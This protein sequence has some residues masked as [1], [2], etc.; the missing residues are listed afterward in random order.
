MRFPNKSIP[1]LTMVVLLLS[2]T[3]FEPVKV[4]KVSTGAVTDITQSSATVEGTVLEIGDAGITQHGFYFSTDSDPS[5][6]SFQKTELGSSSTTGS[7]S[8]LLTGLEP[9]T[10][11]NFMA[12]LKNADGEK[13]GD[14]KNFT[15]LA[16]SIPTV[17]T[18][19]VSSISQT[20]G[21][22]GGTVTDDGGSAVTARGICW[23]ISENPTISDSKTEDGD[24]PGNFVSSLTGLNCGT[25]YFVRAYSTNASGTAYGNQVS[26]TTNQCSANT[27]AL[28]TSPISSITETTAQSGGNVTNDGGSP[29]TIKG[30]CWST[31]ENPTISNSKSVDGNGTGG[32][33]S[34]ISG[35]SCG[36]TYYVR[37]Y[38]TNSSGTAYGNQISFTTSQ[39][40]ANPPTV[41]TSAISSITETTAQGGGEVTSDGGAAVTSKGVCWSTTE[42]PTISD[43]RTEDGTGTGSFT[44]A[45]ADLSCGTTYFV[46]AYATNSSGTSYGVQVSFETTTCPVGL[47][48]VSTS[49][50]TSITEISAQGG[51]SVTD[52]G[53]ASVTAKG[54]C[55]SVSKNPT[56]AD[57]KTND[58]AGTG[59]YTS[60]I[61]GLNCGTTY[62][63]RAYA[64]NTSGTEY[65]AEQAFSTTECPPELAT[66]TT[67]QISNITQTS[68]QGGGN[69][70]SDGG[71]NVTAKGVCWSTSKSPTVSDSKTTDGIGT[72]SFNSVI[73]GLSCGVIYYVRAYV[74]NSAGTA[75]GNEVS[76]TTGACASLP[77]VTTGG[78]S[79]IKPNSAELSGDVASDGGST[80]TAR[81]I[82]WSTSPNPSIADNISSDGSGVGTYT[83]NMTGLS[84][85]TTY[86]A[87]TYASNSAG[88]SYGVQVSFTTG[89]CATLPTVTTDAV[90]SI[91]EYTA[92][93]GGNVTSDGGGTITA[94]GVCWSTSVNPTVWDDFTKD[95]SGTGT[96]GSYMTGLNSYTTYYVRAYATNSTGTGYGNEVT[97][98]TSTVT[99]YDGNEY[100]IVT[101][102]NQ[103]WMA[104]NLNTT[105]YADGS[106]IP[107]VTSDS[108]WTGIGSDERAYCYFNNDKSNGDEY[109][110]L[111][112]WGAASNGVSGGSDTNPS[113]LQG[114][115]PAGYHLPSDAEYMELEMYLGMTQSDAEST[116]EIRGSAQNVGGKLKETGT[117]RWQA[118]NEYATNE[119]GFTAAAGGYRLLDARFWYLPR[120]A[121]YWTSTSEH[122]ATAYSRY[123]HGN[124]GYVSRYP[125][126]DKR[127]GFS[128]R[129]VK[130]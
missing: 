100:R 40:T 36:S 27:P 103:I 97:F 8:G 88:T 49:T 60:A 45:V 90:F 76:F 87:N 24:G 69:V 61:T 124:A 94:R 42:N 32:Y 16:A 35:L 9:G 114:V 13:Y 93:S 28:T 64:T 44:S 122:P 23:S 4:N 53:G 20:S 67:T 91:E 29:V 3:K 127:L 15:T 123:V 68:A 7:F 54:V 51:G 115:C 120:T 30:V 101:I 62:Y 39:C 104:D 73:S 78:L 92:E 106:S 43:N 109:G 108:E 6:G 129:C 46:R 128:V 1:V 56:I 58:G 98:K 26:F 22:G 79:N 47:P 12:Y 77:S 83:G 113:G 112:S 65:G 84:C 59:S 5:S 48:V 80:V 125:F 99:D 130:D 105:H 102:G 81:G 118:P 85:S 19:E 55:W 89:S 75:Y 41:T 18:T 14:I 33:T 121:L 86:Y 70:T 50:I 117:A 107:L 31:S 111:Y 116:G 57:S 34:A 119:S 21:V 52:D 66:V 95:G 110:I 11:Y 74:I 63:V 71:T 2:C 37:S 38:A 17:T 25:T 10:T 126:D 96:F 82:C 72:G